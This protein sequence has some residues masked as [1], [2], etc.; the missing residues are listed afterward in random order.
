MATLG[1]GS[2]ADFEALSSMLS[3]G[4]LEDADTRLP[5][6][7][8]VCTPAHPQS[9]GSLSLHIRVVSLAPSSPRV[10]TLTA[11]AI[12]WARRDWRTGIAAGNGAHS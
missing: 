7:R 8:E 9:T 1:M 5:P 10:R 6:K 2:P 12:G 4:S 11:D 3:A